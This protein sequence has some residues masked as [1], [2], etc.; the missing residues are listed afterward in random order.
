MATYL[1][2]VSQPRGVDLILSTCGETQCY[3][4]GTCRA[5]VAGGGGGLFC[6]CMLGYKGERCED[7]VNESLS[8]YLTLGVLAIIVGFF[9]TAFLCAK[10][11]QKQNRRKR[12][13]L[14][15]YHECNNE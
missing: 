13:A 9:L 3:G 2:P 8:V 15:V 10:I 4:R 12:L 6:D 5:P 7:T 1:A 11:R 14:G